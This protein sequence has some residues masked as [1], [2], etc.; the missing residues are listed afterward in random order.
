MKRTI[1]A[2]FILLI[3]FSNSFAQAQPFSYCANTTWSEP[4]PPSEL[5]VLFAFSSEEHLYATCYIPA[6]RDAHD[7]RIDHNE[8]QIVRVYPFSMTENSLQIWIH[9]RGLFATVIS[10]FSAD[11][12]E[13]KHAGRIDMGYVII[14]PWYP[15]PFFFLSGY[16]DRIEPLG[17]GFW[18]RQTILHGGPIMTPSVHL[19]FRDKVDPF[20][21]QTE[22]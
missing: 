3:V 9:H 8:F 16:S 10:Y 20:E 15:N 18:V 14:M 22:E 4:R 21:Q 1:F 7:C 17:L 6:V 19:L 13:I 5:N 2:V 12:N 11:D